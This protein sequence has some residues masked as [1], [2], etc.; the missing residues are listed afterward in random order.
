MLPHSSSSGGGAELKLKVKAGAP[1]S[2][3]ILLES[4]TGKMS[5]EGGERE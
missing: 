5:P 2:N 1:C 3:I 4:A